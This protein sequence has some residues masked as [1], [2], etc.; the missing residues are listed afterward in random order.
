MRI[1][2]PEDILFVEIDYTQKL[3]Y[4]KQLSVNDF[5]CV[6]IYKKGFIQNVT[7]KLG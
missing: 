7:Y 3:K 5:T 1:V 4:L 6:S 2:V